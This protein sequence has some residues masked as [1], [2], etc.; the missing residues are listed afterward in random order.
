MNALT[1]T[2]TWCA[3]AVPVRTASVLTGADLTG[4]VRTGAVLT[5]AEL[6]GAVSTGADLTGSVLTKPA[7]G[8]RDSPLLAAVD[9]RRG[10]PGLLCATS[11]TH[12]HCTPVPTPAHLT[13]RAIRVRRSPR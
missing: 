3:P 10:L 4:A 12:P 13:P 8:R 5:G 11:P 1:A 2:A 6:T 9:R 7:L